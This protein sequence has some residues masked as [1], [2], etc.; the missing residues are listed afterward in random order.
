M[1]ETIYINNP[2]KRKFFIYIYIFFGICI[3]L[4]LGYYVFSAPLNNKDVTI[5]I[6]SLDTLKSISKELEVKNIVRDDFTLYFISRIFSLNSPLQKGDYK[7][8]KG[9]SVF[10][11]ALQ[12]AQ[13]DYNT[14][15]IKITFREG[16]TN[17]EIANIL[18][19]KLSGFRRDLFI[20]EALSKEG[21]LFPD[22]YLIFPLATSSEIIKEM[23]DNFK[24]RIKEIKEDIENNK[25]NFN[26]IIIMASIIELESNGRNDREMIS[27]ILWKRFDIGM[28]LQVDVDKNTYKEKGLPDKPLCNPGL[29]SIKASLNPKYSSYIYYL[30]DKDGEVH[31][32][33]SY[34]EHKINISKYLK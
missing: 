34:D 24:N 25:R 17:E 30:H 23:N 27:G 12:L 6:T 7:F 20:Q 2:N 21:Y 19:Q 28:P 10:R 13:G 33:K 14:E 4:I 31:Y 18:A 11:V 15:S 5:H 26:D 3:F 22:T 1:E 32:A 16:L 9:S 8:E 29:S